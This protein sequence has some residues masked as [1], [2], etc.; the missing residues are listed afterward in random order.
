[1]GDPASM[2]QVGCVRRTRPDDIDLH[3]LRPPND[4]GG[5]TAALPCLALPCLAYLQG[6]SRQCL[7]T[8]G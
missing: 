5:T 2:A 6:R 1:M 3:V 4:E 8:G 7:S